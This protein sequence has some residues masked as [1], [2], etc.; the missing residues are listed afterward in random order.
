MTP[1]FFQI[2]NRA[3]LRLSFLMVL[4]PFEL[5]KLVY[6]VR[7]HVRCAELKKGVF[8]YIRHFSPIG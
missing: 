8:G 1:T 3:R 6:G 7:A 2:S 5:I 4:T